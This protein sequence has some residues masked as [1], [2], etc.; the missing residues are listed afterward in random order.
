MK[1]NRTPQKVRPKPMKAR[2]DEKKTIDDIRATAAIVRSECATMEGRS[3]CFRSLVM[4]I[5]GQ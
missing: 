1:K 3:L 5:E 4:Q 2:I